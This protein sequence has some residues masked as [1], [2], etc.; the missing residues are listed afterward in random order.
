MIKVLSGIWKKYEYLPADLLQQYV[1]SLETIQKV[2]VLSLFL[3][4]CLS[5]LLSLSLF[6]L[7]LSVTLFLFSLVSSALS[8]LL[9]RAKRQSWLLFLFGNQSY[10]RR[11]MREKKREERVR[12]SWRERVETDT[13]CD[14]DR[15]RKS[16]R[17]TET[18][19]RKKRSRRAE[20]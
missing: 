17:E 11:K 4:I 3:S 12:Q 19:Q 16:G 10:P 13:D 18:P 5:L 14:R 15:Q 2:K 9:S 8:H 6:V 7:Y 20:K 1:T